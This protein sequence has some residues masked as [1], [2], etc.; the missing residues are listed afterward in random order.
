MASKTHPEHEVEKPEI[1]HISD[2]EQ[3]ERQ[4]IAAL[5]GEKATDEATGA[6]EAHDSGTSDDTDTAASEVTVT[7]HASGNVFRR[8]GRWMRSHKMLTIPLF[9]LLVVAALV[10][11]PW[12]RYAIAGTFLK[13]EFKLAVVDSQTHKPVPS[14]RVTLAGKQATTDSKGL[15]A[16]HAPVGTR[17]L[18]VAKKY[19]RTTHATVFVGLGTQK[20]AP[21]T[22][23][24]QATGRQVPV[25]IRNKITNKPLENV[26]IKASGTETKTDK[27]GQATLVVPADKASVSVTVSASGFNTITTDLRV[28]GEQ[29]AA[30]NFLLTPFGK[31]YFLSNQSGKIDVV[32]TDLDGQNRQ[33][34]LAGTGKEDKDTTVLLAARDWKYVALQSLRDGGKNAKLF[35]INTAT[36]QV[37]TMDEGNA[38]FTLV[39]WSDHHFV[40]QVSRPNVQA[41]EPKAQAIKSFDAPSQKL[42]ILDETTAGGASGYDYLQE[43]YSQVFAFGSTVLYGKGWQSSTYTYTTQHAK[44]KQATLNSVHADGTN[45]KTIQGFNLASSPSFWQSSV[46]LE[47]RPYEANELYL[48]FGDGTQKEQFFEFEDGKVKPLTITSQEFYAAYATYLLSPSGKQT[49]W[50]EER[51]GKNAL[52]VGDDEGKNGKQIAALSEYQVYGWYSDDYLLVS[53]KGSELY[54]LPSSGGIDPLK[55]TDYYKPAVSFRGYGGGYGGL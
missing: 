4:Q 38:N 5:E 16:L 34:V 9:V 21:Q 3:I 29:L 30:N 15:A 12:T 20:N 43:E 6:Q 18:E 2:E 31:M 32:K 35:L 33:V 37:T 22:I 1:S 44:E 27:K 46:S 48:R 49:F 41:W 25:T 28:T 55:V 36:D 10:A 40:Y 24:L 8:L 52:F 26:V 13:K 23:S 45:K 17:T 39:G 7:R 54:I 47:L 50:S 11:I 42:T 53:K 19:Y 51:D 14:A